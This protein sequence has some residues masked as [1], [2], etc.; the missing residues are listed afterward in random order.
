M[1][2][3]CINVT[4]SSLGWQVL[5]SSYTKKWQNV[6]QSKNAAQ[7]YFLFN[8]C[9]VWPSTQAYF[10]FHLENLYHGAEFYRHYIIYLNWN[11]FLSDLYVLCSNI[12]P[13]QV[14]YPVFRA[15]WTILKKQKITF[16]PIE[17]RLE[18]EFRIIKVISNKTNVMT[19]CN[20]ER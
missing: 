2:T 13:Y 16:N 17:S 12:L 10:I 8:F 15:H 6:N 5:F 18:L 3:L 14:I 1:Y 7:R 11:Q 4:F 20:W 9:G 19:S